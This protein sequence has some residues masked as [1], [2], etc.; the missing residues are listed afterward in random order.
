MATDSLLC[1]CFC[2]ASSYTELKSSLICFEEACHLMWVKTVKYF[3][4]SDIYLNL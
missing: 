2:Q 1:F 4:N 3:W